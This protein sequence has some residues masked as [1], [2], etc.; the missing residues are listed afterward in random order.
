MNAS[1]RLVMTIV[2][3]IA[4]LGCA[5]LNRPKPE[6]STA[7]GADLPAH[8]SYD[9]TSPPGQSPQTVLQSQVRQAIDTELDGKG[10]E[11]SSD[12]PGFV[13]GYE[14]VE[15]TRGES[16]PPVTIGIGVGSWGHHVGGSVGTSVGVGRGEPDESYRIVVR[17][18]D[19][20]RSRELWVGATTTFELPADEAEIE[21]IVAGMMHGF[22]ARRSP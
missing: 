7:P 20:E 17:A 5:G 13:I 22:P 21:R 3:S 9:W 8:A 16:Y 15:H 4:L 6:W 14:L 19:R 2:T 12:A 18:L 1:A 10:Y 11:K